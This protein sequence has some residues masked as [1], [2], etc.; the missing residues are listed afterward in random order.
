MDRLEGGRRGLLFVVSA[1]SGAGKT[2]LCREMVSLIPNLDYSVSYTTRPIR[3]QETHGKDYSFIDRNEFERLIERGEFAE[4][5]EVHGNLYGTHQGTL[6]K[7]M[8]RGRDVILDVDGQ[9]AALLKARFKE[10]IFIYILPPSLSALKERLDERGADS[11]EEIERR[12]NQARKEIETIDQYS[13]LIV[14]DDFKQASKELEFVICAERL[15]LRHPE[16]EW[17]KLTLL[18]NQPIT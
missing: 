5:A 3:P 12:L 17:I 10:G 8:E 9:G 13:Y 14:N 7:N 1:P 4:W 6:E 11:A 16:N 18:N 15:R 2:T